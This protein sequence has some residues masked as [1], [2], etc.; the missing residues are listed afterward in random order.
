MHFRQRSL[1]AACISFVCTSLSMNGWEMGICTGEALLES[2][3]T[4]HNVLSA[5]RVI[6]PQKLTKTIA[7]TAVTMIPIRRSPAHS[8]WSSPNRKAD[9]QSL[10]RLVW[11]AVAWEQLNERAEPSAKNEAVGPVA[12]C[13]IWAV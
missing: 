11:A 3:A 8:I 1:S 6:V 7:P 4:R 10:D 12:R 2:M 9:T 13:R 5:H